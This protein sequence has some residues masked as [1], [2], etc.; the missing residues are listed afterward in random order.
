MDF[1]KIIKDLR[2]EEDYTQETLA[3]KLN[4]SKATIAMWETGKRLP[5]P[6]KYEEIADFFNVDID[7]LYG[8]T[9]IKRKYSFRGDPDLSGLTNISYPAAYPVP[10][11]GTICAGNGVWCEENYDGEFF[12]DRSVKAD[13]CLR[14]KGD[15]M[16]DAGINDGDYV[17]V[18]K[19]YNYEDG[20]IYAVRING[21]SEAVIKVLHWQ[22][23]FIVLSSSN[24]EYKPIIEL[25]ENVSVIGE[26][27]GIYHAIQ[28]KT[29]G[30]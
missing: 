13:L 21:D 3:A 18:K 8:R 16:I 27:V 23:D 26:C 7:F 20:K 2:M 30:G 25:A 24:A 1:K 28:L 19:V 11:L 14:I 9:N 12:I 4:I 22:D 10:I 29:K 5:S 6:E 17:F 15:S